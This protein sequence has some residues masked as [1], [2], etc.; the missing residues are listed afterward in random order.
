MNFHTTLTKTRTYNT[1][2]NISKVV[3]SNKLREINAVLNGH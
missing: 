2:S 3:V 1:H